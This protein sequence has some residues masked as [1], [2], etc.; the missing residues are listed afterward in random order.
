MK[1]ILSLIFFLCTISFCGFLNGPT[2]TFASDSPPTVIIT[3]PPALS[4]IQGTRYVY[5]LP[6][7]DEDILFYHGYWYRSY[8]GRWYRSRGYNG[9]WTRPK[10]VP[11]QITALPPRF[12]DLG[13]AGERIPYRSLRKHWRGWE[14]SGYWEDSAREAR[15]RKAARKK[16]PKKQAKPAV[17]ALRPP[18]AEPSTRLAPVKPLT[19][20]NGKEQNEGKEKKSNDGAPVVV[21]P[22]DNALKDRPDQPN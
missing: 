16:V 4:V 7:F 22:Q 10:Y 17:K 15:A 1:K 8:S 13:L 6:D 9:P 21:A 5:F 20:T 12:R 11:S 14:R 2:P 19:E 18:E 3:R